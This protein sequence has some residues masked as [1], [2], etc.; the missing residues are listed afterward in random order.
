MAD[1]VWYVGKGGQQLGPFSVDDVKAKLASGDLAAADLAW[2]DGMAE[3]LAI[4]SLADFGGAAPPGAPAAPPMPPSMPAAP[5]GPNPAA[6]FCKAILSDTMIIVNDPDA[7]LTA[8][9]D[10]KSIVFPCVWIGLKVA[11]AALLALE[12]HIKMSSGS[13][14]LEGALQALGQAMASGGAGYSQ[15]AAGTFFKTLL[16]D[17]VSVGVLFGALMLVMAAILRTP[18]ALPKALA[19]VGLSYI[20]LVAVSAVAFV[21]GWASLWFHCLT[22]AIA[23]ATIILFYHLFQHTTQTPRRMAILYVVAIFFAVFL[24]NSGI[25]R[26]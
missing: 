6:E 21:L 5:A 1:A 9:A 16:M 11:F 19:V 23:P 24:I 20:P 8:V 25:S 10:K 7:G 15:S 26:F 2:K 18:D 13:G 4:G 17:A 14:S 22:A 3:W 12:V